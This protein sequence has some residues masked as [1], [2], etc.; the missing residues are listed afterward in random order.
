[1][2][3]SVV[4]CLFSGVVL[5]LALLA[6]VLIPRAEP[7]GALEDDLPHAH[8]APRARHGHRAAGARDRPPTVKRGKDPG[9]TAPAHRPHPAKDKEGVPAL[10][11]G[12][13]AK[14]KDK[15]K[16]EVPAPIDTADMHA[17]QAPAPAREQVPPHPFRVPSLCP[18]TVPLMLSARFNGICNRQ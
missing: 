5:V 14:D 12:P 11:P 16:E 18:A 1:M 3:L 9:T 10:T 8:A 6:Q 13:H 7:R 15:E 17:V 4:L 2:R